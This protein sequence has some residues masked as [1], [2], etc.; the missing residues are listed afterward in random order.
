MKLHLEEV[1]M[2][3]YVGIIMNSNGSHDV[4]VINGAGK[5]LLTFEGRNKRNP[6]WR[7]EDTVRRI[8]KFCIKATMKDWV[9]KVYIHMNNGSEFYA[10]EAYGLMASRF[11]RAPMNIVNDIGWFYDMN[12]MVTKTDVL[13]TK[14]R[15]GKLLESVEALNEELFH[16]DGVDTGYK[17]SPI[18]AAHAFAKAKGL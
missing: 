2:E 7:I 8:E 5:L 13:D 6:S 14:W 15:P 11:G 10:G 12:K 9:A 18:L 3:Y 1:R 16:G 4:S 17:L